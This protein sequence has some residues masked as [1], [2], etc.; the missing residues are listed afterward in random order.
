MST[1]L[2]INVAQLTNLIGK[3]KKAISG[4]GNTD[5]SD[6]VSI[7]FLPEGKHKLRFFL[8]PN[9][10]LDRG[11]KYHSHKGMGKVPCIKHLDNLDIPGLPEEGCSIC[12]QAERGE[13]NPQNWRNNARTNVIMYAELIETNRAGEY[14]ETGTVYAILGP[15]KLRIAF[16]DTM[17]SLTEDS[18]E[19]LISSLNPAI[20]GGYFTVNVTKGTGGTISITPVIGKTHPANAD[21]EDWWVPF[22]EVYITDKY[23][24]EKYLKFLKE[25]VL[26]MNE[27]LEKFEAAGGLVTDSTTVEGVAQQVQQE[28]KKEAVVEAKKE[29][30][31]VKEAVAEAVAEVCGSAHRRHHSGW[32]EAQGHAAQRRK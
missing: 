26:Y 1:A 30:I 11:I 24:S 15:G 17:E 22:S 3:S 28:V 6:S 20:A 9:G 14:W 10:D 32:R 4:N 29:P 21:I 27:E 16:G 5:F 25:F 23:D 8:D 13:D 18:P 19:F 12:K 2:S 7:A 31:V